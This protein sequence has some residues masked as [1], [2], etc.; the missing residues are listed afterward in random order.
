MIS[1][2]CGT[3]RRVRSIQTVAVIPNTGGGATSSLDMKRIGE[4]SEMLVADRQARRGLA[5]PWMNGKSAKEFRAT[6]GRKPVI[7]LFSVGVEE[8]E[9]W[10]DSV[11]SDAE[12]RVWVAEGIANGMRPWFSKFSGVLHDERWLKAVERD[13]SVALPRR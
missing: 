7:G 8:P 4:M 2:S 11:Q 6:M 5:A 1:G 3:T 10:K 13:L 12:I 9:R